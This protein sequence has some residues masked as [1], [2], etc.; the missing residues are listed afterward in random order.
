MNREK[1][2]NKKPKSFRMP[3]IYLACAL[4]LFIC[5]LE[6]RIL[7]VAFLALSGGFL[8]AGTAIA[9]NGSNMQFFPPVAYG[10]ACSQGAPVSAW[11]GAG[12]GKGTYCITL[13]ICATGQYLTSIADAN[14]N[15]SFACVAIAPDPSLA[16][17]TSGSG[18]DASS[19]GTS[20]SATSTS[21]TDSSSNTSGSGGN[22]PNGQYLTW[23]SNCG[24][25][26]SALGNG[27]YEGG[28][29]VAGM[30]VGTG[31]CYYD[32]NGWSFSLHV[33]R[34]CTC[35]GIDQN[36]AYEATNACITANS[37]E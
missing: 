16:S 28:S 17:T 6:M 20:T 2:S 9:R 10:N 3:V 37:D 12:S 24:S 4:F 33:C 32:C 18:T 19:S 1:L 36:A 23:G 29:P 8:A 13:P 35:N 11:N 27:L 7:T 30:S 15:P 31:S 14:G 26:V 5:G 22:C 34:P 25:Q 21:G